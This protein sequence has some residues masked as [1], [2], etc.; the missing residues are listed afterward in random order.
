MRAT[1]EKVIQAQVESYLRA[2][3]IPYFR[4]PDGVYRSIR[5]MG[6]GDSSKASHALTGFP[7]L[8]L[9]KVMPS[10]EV[11][12]LFIELKSAKGVLSAEQ[13]KWQAHLAT[14]VA[15]S[16]EEAVKLIDQFW[17]SKAVD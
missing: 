7:D 5:K 4:V 12:S 17:L 9:H 1:P 2:R 8:S 15:R 10:G 13:K 16:F 11:H 14:K 6:R 3:R